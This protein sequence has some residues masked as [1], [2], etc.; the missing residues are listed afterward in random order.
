[1]NPAKKNNKP[2][3]LKSKRRNARHRDWEKSIKKLSG[4]KDVK[5][6]LFDDVTG[7]Y[8]FVLD[9]RWRFKDFLLTIKE[10]TIAYSPAL[11][12]AFLADFG[13]RGKFRLIR[14]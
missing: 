9:Y 12:S 13:H 11:W 6:F 14:K 7:K 1:M 3:Y 4:A 2:Y 8:V 10:S 5:Y